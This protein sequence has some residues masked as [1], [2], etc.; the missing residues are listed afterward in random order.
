MSGWNSVLRAAERKNSGV[1]AWVPIGDD[2][3]DFKRLFVTDDARPPDAEGGSE[4][5]LRIFGEKFDISLVK[6]KWDGG[7]FE[8]YLFPGNRVYELS[9][10]G[11]YIYQW[12]PPRKFP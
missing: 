5:W 8:S 3:P 2:D 6:E 11:A 12:V 9:Y 10:D 4:A 1:P 7:D